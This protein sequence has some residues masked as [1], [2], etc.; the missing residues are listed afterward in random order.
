MTTTE[1]PNGWTADGKT[2]LAPNGVPVVRGIRECVLGYAGIAKAPGGWEPTNLPL[3]PEYQAGP[4][5][6]GNAGIGAAVGR[7]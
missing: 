5:E 6:P 2:L 1:A 4:S 7:T 3:A